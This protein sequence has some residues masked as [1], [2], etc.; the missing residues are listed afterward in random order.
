MNG[1]RRLRA[2][3]P[4]V[5]AG[6]VGLTLVAIATAAPLRSSA[7]GEPTVLRVQKFAPIAV[8]APGPMPDWTAM[9]WQSPHFDETLLGQPGPRTEPTWE[10]L[11]SLSQ[12]E[13]ALHRHVRVPRTVPEALDDA[14][15]ITLFGA[16]SSSY[17]LD[18]PKINRVLADA[19][20][21]D[22]QLPTSLH[23]ARLSFDVP[24]GVTLHWGDRRSG[25][26]LIQVRQ[27]T[28]TVPAE[29]DVSAL[30]DLALSDPRIGGANPDGVAQLRAIQDWQTTLPIPVRGDSSSTVSIDG[31]EGLLVSDARTGTHTLLWQRGPVLYGLSGR[32]DAD[33]LVS[34]AS[35]LQ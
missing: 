5:A 32:V 9:K 30:R 4:A 25:M 34:V 20:V 8:E 24:A 16:S 11:D 2:S 10:K 12:A 13:A 35:S 6:I 29:V 14:P 17:M 27:P 33:I 7:F 18:L 26:S 3:A 23:G 31:A 1:I 22:V 28:L 19:G 15:S 21:D